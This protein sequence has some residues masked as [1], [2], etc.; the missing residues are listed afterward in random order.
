VTTDNRNGAKTQNKEGSSTFQNYP[1]P[2]T[3]AKAG[4]HVNSWIPAFAGMTAGRF[5]RTLQQ[6]IIDSENYFIYILSE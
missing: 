1:Q 2:V 3:P 4:V 6:T 5:P